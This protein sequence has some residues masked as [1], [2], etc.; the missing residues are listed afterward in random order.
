M[1]ACTRQVPV[2]MTRD[3]AILPLRIFATCQSSLSKVVLSQNVK[4]VDKHLWLTARCYIVGDSVCL[5]WHSCQ[6]D[7]SRTSGDLVQSHPIR[8]KVGKFKYF[9][10][11][12]KIG[13][14]GCT[15]DSCGRITPIKPRL[16]PSTHFCSPIFAWTRVF[17]RLKYD[18]DRSSQ[19]ISTFQRNSRKIFDWW[20]SYTYAENK[21]LSYLRSENRV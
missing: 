10:S 1:T 13:L 7:W 18:P 21:V 4:I 9:E 2:S 16:G 15:Y 19:V 3:D 17:A 8:P 20:P 14:L 11:T 6:L 5:C 12:T